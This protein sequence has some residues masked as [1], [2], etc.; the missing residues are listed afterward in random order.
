MQ[1]ETISYK[2]W[3]N[4]YRLSNET[5]EIIVTGDVGP[6]IIHFGFIGG[7]NVF[8]QFPH[9][10]GQSGGRA[11]RF[12]GGHRLWHAPENKPRTYEPDNDPVDHFELDGIH[13]FVPHPEESTGIQKQIAV[14]FKNDTVVID[15]TLTNTGLWAVELAP[16]AVTMMAAGGVGIM[17]L[18][19]HVSHELQLLPTHSLSL[20][21]YTSLNDRRIYFGDKYI[22]VMQ[23]P[24]IEA[25]LKIGLQVVPEYVWSVGWL[26]Y[27]NQGV[28]FVKSF[29]PAGANGDYPDLGSQVEL[30]ADGNFLELE[31]LG[32]KKIVKPEESIKHR[33]Y[34]SLHKDVPMPETDADIGQNIL[35]F[36]REAHPMVGR[37]QTGT[38]R[39]VE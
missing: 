15:H 20:W 8:K 12:Y 24:E 18:P 36:I 39:A 6:R 35:P 22:L 38:L 17:P 32:N 23:T 19:P 26:A 3:A 10:I 13:Y 25:P 14:H 21:G 29:H 16:W 33:E 31:T 27:V 1:I 9:D 4:C 34:W 7:N 37:R 30:F 11:Y 28:M 5:I 2:G